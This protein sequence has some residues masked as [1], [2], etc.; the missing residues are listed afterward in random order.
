MVN[1]I[2]AIEI[3]TNYYSQKSEQ[4]ITKVYENENSWIVF[5]GKKNM[6]RFGSAGISIDKRT[7]ETSVFM[8]PNREN[9]EILRNSVLIEPK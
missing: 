1:Y 6:P 9:F 3:A 5:A 2:E 4:E 8:L 7:A